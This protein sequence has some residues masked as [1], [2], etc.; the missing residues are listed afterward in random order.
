MYMEDQNYFVT[1][2]AC[3][4]VNGAIL[5]VLEWA[6]L[7]VSSLSCRHRWQFSL[8]IFRPITFRLLVVCYSTCQLSHF[9]VRLLARV[10][11]KLF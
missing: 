9:A 7:I 11:P 5:V 2:E 1:A 10:S 4:D 6:W 8:S 3:I